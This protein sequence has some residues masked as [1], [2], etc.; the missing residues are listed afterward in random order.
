MD[1]ILSYFEHLPKYHGLSW[2]F[3]ALPTLCPLF[4]QVEKG[5]EYV[6]CPRLSTRGDEGV[7]IGQNLV[8]VV[9][10]CPLIQIY[11]DIY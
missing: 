11:G 1:Q 7:K 4:V 5:G 2:T 6:K 3:G 10:E 9:V 8:H